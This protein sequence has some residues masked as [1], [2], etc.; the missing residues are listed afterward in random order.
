MQHDLSKIL[1]TKSHRDSSPE[2]EEAKLSEIFS[3]LPDH[4]QSEYEAMPAHLA[5]PSYM[6]TVVP[7]H[8]RSCIDHRGCY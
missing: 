7:K 2:N 3:E 1:T 6:N 8:S 5:S 4:L